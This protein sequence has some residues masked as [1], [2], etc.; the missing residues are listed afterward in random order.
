MYLIMYMYLVII[1]GVD[2]LSN[3]LNF[4][5]EFAIHC[6]FQVLGNSISSTKKYAS[7]SIGPGQTVQKCK[8]A[9]GKS[10]LV[11]AGSDKDAT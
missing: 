10:V 5:Y 11:P 1:I 2:F 6:S 8:V 3:L 4:C 7:S 9:K